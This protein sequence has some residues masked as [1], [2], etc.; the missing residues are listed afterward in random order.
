[1]QSQKKGESKMKNRFIPALL[2]AFLGCFT[3]ASSYAQGLLKPSASFFQE[4]SLFYQSTQKGLIESLPYGHA[5]RFGIVR[6]RTNIPEWVLRCDVSGDTL[7]WIYEEKGDVAKRN[8]KIKPKVN[9]HKLAI[10]AIQRDALDSLFLYSVATTQAEIG[11]HEHQINGDTFI[12]MAKGFSAKGYSAEEGYTAELINIVQDLCQIVKD[13]N[14]AALLLLMPKV[15]ELTDAY[16]KIYI[17]MSAIA[18]REIP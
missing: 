13:G 18:K 2:C 17:S 11:N 16:R 9:Q 15:S 8:D 6:V 5:L 4:S 10:S 3:S 1:M 12:F 14:Q 7:Q